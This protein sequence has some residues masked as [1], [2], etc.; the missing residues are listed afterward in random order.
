MT[1][2]DSGSI[3]IFSV[4]RRRG[5]CSLQRRRST[6]STGFH[7]QLLYLKMANCRNHNTKDFGDNDCS[8]RYTDLGTIFRGTLVLDRYSSLVIFRFVIFENLSHFTPLKKFKLLQIL[9][10]LEEQ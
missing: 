6:V 8:F 2:D 3:F 7:L 1:Y 4:V 5:H 9:N 10:C